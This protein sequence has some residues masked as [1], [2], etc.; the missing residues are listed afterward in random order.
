MLNC[1]KNKGLRRIASPCESGG[2]GN[3]TRVPWHFNA[4]VYVRSPSIPG[5]YRMAAPRLLAQTPADRV[6]GKLSVSFFSNHR[7]RGEPVARFSG[8]REPDLASAGQ[9]FRRRLTNGA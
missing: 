5:A 9:S 1:L 2:A 3:R 8:V 6:L 4:G 7:H